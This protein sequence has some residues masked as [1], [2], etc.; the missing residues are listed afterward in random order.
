MVIHDLDR[1]DKHRQL[2][3][4]VC[5]FSISAPR[6]AGIHVMLQRYA[7]VPESEIAAI[8]SSLDPDGQ[9]RPQVAFLEFGGRR[10]QPVVPSLSKLARYVNEVVDLFERECFTP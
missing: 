2:A 9:I 7:G 6:M 3:I 1:I 4:A 10:V 5:G 8:A